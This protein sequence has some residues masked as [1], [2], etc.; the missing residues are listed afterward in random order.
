MELP[1]AEFAK[2]LFMLPLQQHLP[3]WSITHTTCMARAT[4]S[5]AL[6]YL[7]VPMYSPSLC[8]SRTLRC[9]M[10]NIIWSLKLILAKLAISRPSAACVRVW[11]VCAWVCVGVP[12]NDAPGL[13]WWASKSG[14]VQAAA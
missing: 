10:A 8:L 2:N 4:A 6:F 7:F 11:K 12:A 3:N 9:P 14:L 5:C 1:V 13:S